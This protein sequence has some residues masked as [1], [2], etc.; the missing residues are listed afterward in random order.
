MQVT[1]GG[2]YPR[3]TLHLDE[4]FQYL[5]QKKAEGLNTKRLEKLH[6][7]LDLKSVTFDYA[8]I[9]RVVAITNSNLTITYT[10]D[11]LYQISKETKNPK[12]D[13]QQISDYLK[14]NFQPAIS[15][16]FSRGAP[17]PKLLA[18]I[19]VERPTVFSIYD[20]N[21]K[22]HTPPKSLGKSD[23]K[24]HSQSLTVHFFP[25]YIYLVGN[26]KEIIEDV[27]SMQIFFR[28]F[29]SQLAK[30]LQIHRD[31]WEK[32]D[33]L[34]EKSDIKGS[35]ISDVFTELAEYEKTILLIRNRLNQMGA[36]INTRE[37][38]AGQLNVQEA[39]QD[40]FKYRFEDL[41]DSLSYIQEIWV[42]TIDYIKQTLN[43]LDSLQAK[44][45]GKSIRSI[46]VLASIGVLAGFL[47][48]FEQDTFP[49]LNSV[50]ITYFIILVTAA[51][52]INWSMKT[53]YNSKNYSLSTTKFKKL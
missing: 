39:M 8:N 11:G 21:H 41:G 6:K 30:Y 7:A 25:K 19:N 52:L 22:K 50:G 28:E 20:K 46:Q 24:I 5:T 2:W 29:K 1:V 18:E 27:V 44:A 53:Y 12:K 10:E 43:N 38:L 32:V 42:M 16:L 23:G 33:D 51:W 49:T 45:T 17:T 13:E 26:K 34:T 15:Y 36:Y 4:V 40:L 48:Y 35:E 14:N 47:R 31:I 37:E 3:T 9:D